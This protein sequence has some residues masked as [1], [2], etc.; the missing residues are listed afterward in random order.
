MNIGIHGEYHVNWTT[1]HEDELTR[2]ISVSRK[3]LNE[4]VDEDV[5]TVAVPFGAYNRKVLS[6]LRANRIIRVY[7]S[8]G[9]PAL[10]SSWLVS[11]H[12]VRT[13]TPA[14]VVQTW[15]SRHRS[16]VSAARVLLRQGGINLVSAGELRAHIP[17]G[18]FANMAFGARHARMGRMQIRNQLRF[19]HPMASL[20]AKLD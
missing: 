18:P 11:R 20:A 14:A 1:L 13:D 9:G 16:I 5:R 17:G 15:I 8:D 7:T 6:V 19:H 4:I 2:Q 12:T 10:D 3:V